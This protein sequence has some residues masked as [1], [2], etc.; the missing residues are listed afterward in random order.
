[1][2]GG[3]LRSGRRSRTLQIALAIWI[4]VLAALLLSAPLTTAS[5][6]YKLT[7]RVLS[8]GSPAPGAI[9]S[10]RSGSTWV[11]IGDPTTSAGYTSGN[12]ADG[13]YE[14]RA[15]AAGFS[16]SYTN[17]TLKGASS[18]VTMSL[19]KSSSGS[20]PTP[21]RHVV[22]IMDEN[23]AIAAALAQPFFSYLAH[24]YAYSDN[25]FSVRHD[26]LNDYIAATSGVTSL[27]F[28][29]TETNIGDLLNTAGLSWESFMQSIPYPCDVT[30]STLYNPGHDPFI[31]YQD[32]A[33]NPSVCKAKVLPLTNFSADV[34][35]SALPAYSWIS[36]NQIDD[37]HGAP[38]PGNLTAANDWLRSFLS[39]LVN[40]SAIFSNTVFFITF[41]EG[42]GNLPY[43]T[44][45]GQILTIAV[46]PYA[47]HGLASVIPYDT[48]SLLTTTEWLLDLGHTGHN[49]SWTRS[50]PMTDLFSFDPIYS[51]TGTVTSSSGTVLA[52]A[53]ITDPVYTWA[54]SKSAGTFTLSPA[55]GTYNVTGTAPGYLPDERTLTVDGASITN[56]DL[57][58]APNPI[59]FTKYAIT[60][61]VETSSSAPI[62]KATIDWIQNGSLMTSSTSSK[63]QF[64]AQLPNGT[65]FLQANAKGYEPALTA[66]VVSGRAE[67]VATFKLATLSPTT[68]F[69][70]TGRTTYS[71][72][73]SLAGATVSTFNQTGV[74]QMVSN[75]NGYLL[76]WLPNGEYVWTMQR[77]GLIWEVMTGTVDNGWLEILPY[78]TTAVLR[79]V[80]VTIESSSGSPVTSGS[81]NF[82]VAGETESTSIGSHGVATFYVPGGETYGFTVVAPGY[83]Y[84]TKLVTVSGSNLNLGVL[85][86]TT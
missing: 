67:S 38:G 66:L 86:L 39:P 83:T 85:K 36:P 5:T 82:I 34:N 56:F 49:D 25:F 50:P 2:A 45:G 24:T 17:V 37:G 76:E 30:N 11:Q 84:L 43:G 40:D 64:T 57:V 6:T 26:S 80:T 58:L 54:T 27:A 10:Y 7:I 55:N 20:F 53:N 78:F 69:R 18:T 14:L 52:G 51:V 72:G 48:V 16:A 75:P 81:V 70:I 60:G 42:Y 77:S 71:N 28:N 12:L 9:V 79:S 22:V 59:Y 65:Y 63:G 31:H 15:T 32:I 47:R 44:G 1:M 8:S 21:I 23:A 29:Q 33:S 19:S 3:H 41:D 73:T 61:T 68:N 46:S 35:A 13:T 4:A 74:T 62:A